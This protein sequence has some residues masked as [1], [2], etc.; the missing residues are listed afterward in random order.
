MGGQV[1]SIFNLLNAFSH[2]EFHRNGTFSLLDNLGAPLFQQS[3]LQ[4]FYNRMIFCESGETPDSEIT[5][6]KYNISLLQHLHLVGLSVRLT[7]RNLC[8]TLTKFLL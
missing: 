4:T 8:K 5:C 2:S 6:P 3:L 7:L 1:S